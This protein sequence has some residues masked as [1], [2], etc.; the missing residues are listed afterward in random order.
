MTLT[1]I[2]FR[3]NDGATATLADYAGKV[4]LVVNTASRCGLT[5][6]YE[7]LE[8]LY[9][10]LADDGLVIL[11]FPA[12]DF[13]GQEPGTDEEIAAFCSTTYGVTFP[14]MAK[15]SV[16][17]EEKHPLYAALTE[18]SDEVQWNFEKFLIGRD[19]AVRARFAPAVVPDA[20]EVT[21]AIASALAQ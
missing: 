19:G 2:E 1:D 17:G 13:Q 10:D 4:V 16:L 21:E 18:G 12:N 9:A 7:G 11:A 15:I 5:P 14:L 3:T 6:Q 20:P 8:R